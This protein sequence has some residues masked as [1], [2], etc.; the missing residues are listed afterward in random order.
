MNKAEIILHLVLPANHELA[1]VMQ[2]GKE[3]FHLPSSA[4]STKRTTILGMRAALCSVQSDQF[5]PAASQ[6]PLKS[7]TV[8]SSVSHESFRTIGRKTFPDS[9]RYKGDFVWRST[10]CVDGDRKT[11]RVSHCHEFRPLPTASFADLK[12]PFLLVQRSHP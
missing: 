9:L 2:P 11:M 7:I 1:K 8:V 3:L 5:Y 10:G 12:A 4:L 6:G